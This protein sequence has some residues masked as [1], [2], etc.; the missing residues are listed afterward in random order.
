[1]AAERE[2]REGK[3]HSGASRGAGGRISL[4]GA[5]RLRL[6]LGAT[7]E[8]FSLALS[9]GIEG[10][11]GSPLGKRQSFYGVAAAGALLEGSCPGGPPSHGGAIPREALA[12]IRWTDRPVSDYPS[13][14]FAIGY[15]RLHR[16]HLG[17][18]RIHG[19]FVE[20]PEEVRAGSGAA[21]PG[22]QVR[23]CLRRRCSHRGERGAGGRDAFAL[24]RIF[25]APT[26]YAGA[27]LLLPECSNGSRPPS[28]ASPTNTVR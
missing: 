26:H 23:E 20:V 19:G 22:L 8:S 10:R 25:F 9:G 18:S 6:L 14:G 7:V 13:E 2:D 27:F 1:M 3:A 4:L 17:G 21:K 5:M 15:P 11:P 16:G 24:G 12:P 28:G